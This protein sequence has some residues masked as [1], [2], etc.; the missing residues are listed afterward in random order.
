MFSIVSTGTFSITLSNRSS[1]LDVQSWRDMHRCLWRDESMLVCSSIICFLKSNRDLLTSKGNKLP[2]SSFLVPFIFMF[3]C[4]KYSHRFQSNQVKWQKI[5]Y[6]S[7]CL[8]WGLNPEP[9]S[10]EFSA[11]RHVPYQ[12]VYFLHFKLWFQ[13]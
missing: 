7:S 13:N 12:A 6:Y 4:S 5:F 3:I 1:F 8:S 9:F 11:L 10:P 2:S